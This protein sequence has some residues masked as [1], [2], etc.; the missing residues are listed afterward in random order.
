MTQQITPLACISIRQPWAGAIICGKDVENRSRRI[1]HRGL[2]GIHATLHPDWAAI[3]DERIRALLS[4]TIAE[5]FCGLGVVLGVAQ[6]VDCH[7]DTGS[8]CGP[9]AARG[10]HHLVLTDVRRLPEP[11]PARG[12]LALPWWAPDHVAAAVHRQL[13]VAAR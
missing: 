7:P 11:V 3:G 10:L 2:V 13:T 5:P 9:W 12:S 1:S 4:N 6:L 8:C